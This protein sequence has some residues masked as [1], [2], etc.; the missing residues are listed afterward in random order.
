MPMPAEPALP[1]TAP[2]EP[3]GAPN[4]PNAATVPGPAPSPAWTQAIEYRVFADAYAALNYGLPKPQTGPEDQTRAYDQTN[5]FSLAWAGVDVGHPADPVGG[6]LSL[7]FGPSAERYAH[8]CGSTTVP[9]DS[10][11]GLTP[12]KQAY[13]SWRPG[14][15]DSSLLLKLGKFDTIY[16]AEVAESQDNIDYTRGLLYWLGQPLF[17]TGLLAEWDASRSFVLTGM[18]VNGYNNTVDNNSG[19]SVGLQAKLRLPKAPATDDDVLVASLGY[20]GGPEHD[21]VEVIDCPRDEVVDPASGCVSSP[22]SLGDRYVRDRAKSNTAGLRH[23]VDLVVNWAPTDEVLVVANGDFGVDSARAPVA[24]GAPFSDTFESKKWWGVMLAARYAVAPAFSIGVR[25]EY[26]DDI[27][28]YLLQR[29]EL[30]TVSGVTIV[31]GTKLASGTL[32]LRANAGKNL[33]VALDNR[34]D[35]ADHAVFHSGVRDTSSTQ[36]T[37]TL[38]VVV[39]TD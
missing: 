15:A 6:K 36:I 14:G 8:S 1:G 38:G 13:A 33:S 5:G 22:G 26:V 28:G 25:G 39:T 24:P 32:T 30:T 2:T 18:V 35:W 17:H 29:E 21:D 12:V 9:C 27:D 37:S 20:L 3:P 7:R 16:G 4:T 34:F 19:K 11:I 10:D 31:G 23:L